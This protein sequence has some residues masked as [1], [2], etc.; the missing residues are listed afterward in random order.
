MPMPRRMPAEWEKHAGC[1]M[2]WPV[3]DTAWP[4]NLAAVQRDY[5]A[6]AGA[7]RSFEPLTMI[8]AAEAAENARRLLGEDIMLL[9]LPYDDAWV[10]DSGPT[11]V[12]ENGQ[13]LAAVTWRFNGWGGAA[14]NF[15]LDAKLNL[16]I[17]RHVGVKAV[18]SALA[19]EGG[20]IHVD[21]EGTLLTTE[22]VVFNGNRNP[23]ITREAV[24]AEFA[25]TLGIEKTI[26]LPGNPYEF[27][28][29]GHI[30]GI[31]C[32]VR[33]GVVMFETSASSRPQYREVAARNFAALQ[34][35]TDARGRKLELVFIE[36]A[37]DEGRGK[38]G[39]W[40]YSTSYVNFYIAND[41]IVMPA[42]GLAQQDAA[43]KAAAAAAF[44]G[45]RIEQVDISNLAAGGGG[46]HCITQQIPL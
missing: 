33:P 28:T 29:N 39:E 4:G 46:I 40:G 11:F 17:A 43:A 24:E 18:N 19:M 32:F 12:R 34:N 14:E 2:I 7:I 1:V 9:T 10:R 5:A 36:E 31:A 42:F 44:P 23:G 13:Q 16:A 45:R 3:S 37:P 41:G 8:V 15:N 22:T 30:D 26:W 21:G 6:V 25:R 27:G 20:A 38:K 35:Q